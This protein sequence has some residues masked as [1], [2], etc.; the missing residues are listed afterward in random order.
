M[1]EDLQ[2]DLSF[3]L[4]VKTI[5]NQNSGIKYDVHLAERN[6]SHDTINKFF[7]NIFTILYLSDLFSKENLDRFKEEKI[8]HK[9]IFKIYDLDYLSVAMD[10]FKSKPIP[11]SKRDNILM[12][13]DFILEIVD[14]IPFS[15]Y[16]TLLEKIDLVDNLQ[17]FKDE[18]EIIDEDNNIYPD[19]YIYTR[20][21]QK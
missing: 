21:I 12:A 16:L 6:T 1:N 15:S 20:N 18:F 9:A 14:D 3:K 8:S 5:G 17:M 7:D 4:E 13:I 2:H 11:Y 19:F 10:Y